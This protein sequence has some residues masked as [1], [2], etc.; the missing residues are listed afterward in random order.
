MSRPDR[1]SLPLVAILSALVVLAVVWVGVKFQRPSAPEAPEAQA[2]A[3]PPAAA[4]GRTVSHAQGT[5]V[6]PLNPRRVIAFDLVALD[7]LQALEVD[8]L[9]VAGDQFPEHLARYRDAKYLRMGTLFEPDYEAIHAARPDLII[10]GGR[11]SAKYANLSRLAPTVDLPMSGKDYL[12]TVVANTELLAGIFGKEA[13]AQALVAELRQSIATLKETTAGRGRG[14]VVLVTGGRMSAYG[15]G[16]RFGVIHDDFGIPVAAEGLN[17]SLHGEVIGSEFIREK[18]PDWLFVI[19][20]DA[21]MGQPGGGGARQVLD[22]ELVHQTSAWQK[23]QV[24]YLDPGTSYLAGGGIQAVR[25]MRDQVASAYA[26]AGSSGT[27]TP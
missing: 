16:S 20:R 24:V 22:N 3:S 8:V 19:D 17:P 2:G 18:N 4:E 14:L 21:A 7:I 12:A 10:T 1:R 11:S 25:H 27:P 26:R 15:P 6:V 23:G 5:T 9:G 13:K